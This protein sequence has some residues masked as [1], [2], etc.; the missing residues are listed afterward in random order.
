M[1]KKLLDGY[2]VGDKTFKVHIDGLNVL[3]WLT[4]HVKGEPQG[5]FLL[6]QR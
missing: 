6:H 1:S 3:P 2:A 5:V 4:G